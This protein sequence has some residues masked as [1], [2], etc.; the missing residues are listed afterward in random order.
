[1]AVTTPSLIAFRYSMKRY[2]LGIADAKNIPIVFDRSLAT[3]NLRNNTVD[4]WIVPVYGITMY[5]SSSVQVELVL[6][7]CTRKDPEWEKNTQ[8]LEYFKSCL[9]NAY[10]H[11]PA[12]IPF[13][14]DEEQTGVINVTGISLQR[15]YDFEDQTK[16]TPMEVQLWYPIAFQ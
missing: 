15:A 10:Y 11:G 16:V 12:P 14:T 1:M 6:N 5:S 13:Y 8:L 7:I 2:L 9:E 4:K 3:P